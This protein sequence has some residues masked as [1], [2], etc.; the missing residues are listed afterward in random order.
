M[1]TRWERLKWFVWRRWHR[2]RCDWDY[3]EEL[4]RRVEVEAELLAVAKSKSPLPTREQCLK[5][6]LRLGCPDRK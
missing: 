4:N 6:A 5:W 3:A 2:L 1:T